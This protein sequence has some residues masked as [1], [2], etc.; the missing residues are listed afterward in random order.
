MPT[1]TRLTATPHTPEFTATDGAMRYL[2]L[3]LS[4]RGW[5]LA[6]TTGRGQVARI[7]KIAAGALEAL[8]ARAH[9]PDHRRESRDGSKGGRRANRRR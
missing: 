1:T 2:A 4:Q 3:E 8:E 7:R 6:F 9:H 5:T